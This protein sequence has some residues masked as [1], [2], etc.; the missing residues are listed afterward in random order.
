MIPAASSLVSCGRQD[1]IWAS[2]LDTTRWGTLLSTG[3]VDGDSTLTSRRG[4]GRERPRRD[5]GDALSSMI[6][7]TGICSA[8][9]R[10]DRGTPV[11]RPCL[12]ASAGSVETVRRDAAVAGRVT[13]LAGC[14]PSGPDWALLFPCGRAITADNHYVGLLASTSA[15]HSRVKCV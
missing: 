4:V 14:A 6:G 7:E 8:G 13:S 10:P 9:N 5:S 2:G 15:D 3:F 12:S 11:P 1:T